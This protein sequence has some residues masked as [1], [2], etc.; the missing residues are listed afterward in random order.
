MQEV[1]TRHRPLLGDRDIGPV[2]AKVI[3]PRFMRHIKR[4]GHM[5]LALTALGLQ[6][7]DP[8]LRFVLKRVRRPGHSLY[9]VDGKAPEYSRPLSS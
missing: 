7:A 5:A 1:L 2:L 9:W 8:L 6:V 3:R 4:C